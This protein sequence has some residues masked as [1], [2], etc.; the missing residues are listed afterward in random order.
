MPEDAKVVA[1]TPGS[2]MS[3]VLSDMLKFSNNYVAEMLTK[4]VALAGGA[5]VGTIKGGLSQ[6]TKYLIEL[7]LRQDSLFSLSPSS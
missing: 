4:Q 6:I 1:L 2:T 7:G 5:K 3:Q